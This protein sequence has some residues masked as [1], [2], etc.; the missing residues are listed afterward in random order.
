MQVPPRLLEALG[1]CKPR[2][3][4]EQNQFSQ[5]AWRHPVLIEAGGCPGSFYDPDVHTVETFA[6]NFI[7]G[8]TRAFGKKV[9]MSY[10]DKHTFCKKFRGV[11]CD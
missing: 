11:K 9:V 8:I 4:A 10:P 3:K 2:G 7:G 1:Y 6:D 5:H